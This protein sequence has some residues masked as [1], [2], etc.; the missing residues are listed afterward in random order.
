MIQGI[1]YLDDLLNTMA[2]RWPDNRTVNI[3]C[4]GHS[5][6]S[7]YFATPFVDPFNAYPH[8]LHRMVKER[9]P[10]AV[11]NVIV[12]AIGGENAVSGA[13][14]FDRDVLCHQPDL[15]V[16]DYSLNDRGEEG[17]LEAAR[18]AWEEMIRKAQAY[19]AKV[20]LCTP[21]W[22]Y[23][24]FH[25]NDHWSQLVQHADQVRALAEEYSTGLADSFAAFER[26]VHTP[27]ELPNYMSHGN[28][29]TRAGHELVALEIGKYFVAR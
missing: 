12:T 16:I 4:H 8:L 10:Y 15:V 11:V 20:I 24:Y 23:S 6:P 18:A 22:D 7:G 25:Q 1:N 28:H 19:G 9:F 3:V 27:L 17:S 29:P 2:R 14:R 26:H 13:A 21:T 5:V